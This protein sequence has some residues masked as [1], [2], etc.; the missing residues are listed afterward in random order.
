[1]AVHPFAEIQFRDTNENPFALGLGFV[2]SLK[3]KKDNAVFNIEIYAKF[4]DIG[5]AL[6]QK[7]APFYNRNEIGIN[8]AVPLNFPKK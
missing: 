3:N 2:K 6:P 5:R 1:M 7:E 4:K 8:F